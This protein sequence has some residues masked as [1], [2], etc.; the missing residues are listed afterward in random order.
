MTMA[1]GP[2]SRDGDAPA[3]RSV[4]RAARILGFFTASR[5]RLTL[6]QITGRLGV[7]KATA[8]RY[9]L[10]L[11]EV[12]LL[13]YD[14]ATAEYTLGPQVLTLAAAARAGVPIIGIAGPA[15][16]KLVEEANETAVLSVWDGEVPIVVRV[17]DGTERQIRLSVRAGTRLSPFES[18]QGRIFCAF[19]PEA[20]VPGLTEALAASPMLRDELARVR[21][22]HLA[23]N[24]PHRHGV[25]TI[26]APIFG[27]EGIAAAVALVGT[28]AELSEDPDS[29]AAKALRRAAE[30]V[31]ALY[32]QHAVRP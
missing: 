21:E 1:E 28:T 12:N 20:D 5:P 29:S 17:E 31:T 15:M 30:N 25:R 32:G 11:R 16:E 8:H 26:A 10:A 27:E 4:E 6:S 7:S 13:R 22:S 23:L 19:L 3:I 2:R 14:R 24:E 9:T 18:A